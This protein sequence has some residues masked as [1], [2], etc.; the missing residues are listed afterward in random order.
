MAIFVTTL[1]LTPNNLTPSIWIAVALATLSIALIGW[2]STKADFSLSWYLS[3]RNWC[4]WFWF[5]GLA[6]SFFTNQS[7]PF[8]SF[9]LYLAPLVYFQFCLSRGQKDHLLPIDQTSDLW[10]WLSAHSYG[11]QAIC[12]SMAI[13]FYQIPTQ[14]NIFYAGRGISGLSF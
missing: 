3:C 1:S 8:F 4:S 14:A 10:M 7:D 5:I 2:P 9:L 11:G 13:G 12:M 6:R